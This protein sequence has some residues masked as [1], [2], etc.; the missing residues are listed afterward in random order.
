MEMTPAK[1]PMS[2]LRRLFRAHATLFHGNNIFTHIGG[3]NVV[4]AYGSIV[5]IQKKSN[6]QIYGNVQIIL[7][8]RLSYNTKVPFLTEKS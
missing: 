6:S 5:N 8:L 4:P 7:Y 3:Y 1:F 2:P